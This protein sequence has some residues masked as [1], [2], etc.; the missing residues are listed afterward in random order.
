[1]AQSFSLQSGPLIPVPQYLE[2]SDADD[3]FST[4][5]NSEIWFNASTQ[6]KQAALVTATR[7]MDNLNYVGIKNDRTQ[8][9]EFPRQPRLVSSNEQ[10]FERAFMP[11][12]PKEIYIACCE[13]AIVRLDSIDPEMEINSL[14]VVSTGY[15]SVREQVDRAIPNEATRAGIMSQVAW[16]FLVPWLADPLSFHLTKV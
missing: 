13:E 10:H 6:Q 3:Y 7:A 12:I 9:L 8:L 5:L 2:V 1:M 14:G 4:R 15:A 16:N 11:T